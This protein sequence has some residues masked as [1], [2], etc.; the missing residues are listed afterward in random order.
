MLANTNHEQL[1]RKIFD[2]TSCAIMM[3][4][5]D[6]TILAINNAFTNVTGY[7]REEILGKNPRIL[8]S[9]RHGEEFYV[10]FWQT[11]K[12]KGNWQGEIW[13]RR[14][15]GE[16]YLQ[17]ANI[18]SIEENN[19]THYVAIFSDITTVKNEEDRL[20]RMAYYDPL[21]NLPN[22][23]LLYERLE[24]AITVAKRRE[25]LVAVLFLDLDNFKTIND[26]LGHD[27]GDQFLQQVAQKMS[28]VIREND[29][30][31]RLGGDEFIILLEDIKEAKDS[32]I[33]AEKIIYSVAEIS[34]ENLKAGVSI[35]IAIGPTDGKN[36]RSLLRKAD[37]AMYKAKCSGKNSFS[38]YDKGA[39]YMLRTQ[40]L[41][42]EMLRSQQK[43][44]WF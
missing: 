19:Q 35:G 42:Y 24:H 44:N 14:K 12:S 7:D 11:L 38:F 29:T 40:R 21:T 13:N 2:A 36:A 39:K 9:C 23:L 16:V 33:V 5:S 37:I 26:T 41:N 20:R 17:W 10:Q 30:V 25:S 27:V 1:A 32:E 34:I 6:G 3:T 4:D 8:N 43:N 31:A 22:R 28:S 18:S 15:N